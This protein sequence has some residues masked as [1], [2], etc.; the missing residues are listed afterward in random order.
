MND[1]IDCGLIGDLEYQFMLDG[2]DL[3]IILRLRKRLNVNI[4]Q[5]QLGEYQ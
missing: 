2:L 3:T 5:T 4:R 1:P